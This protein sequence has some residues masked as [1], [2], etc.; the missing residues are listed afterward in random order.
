MDQCDILNAVGGGLG[1]PHKH[2]C[3][4]PQGCPLSMMLIAF[5]LRPWVL[6]MIRLGGVP[7]IL[8]DDM[9]VYAQGTNLYFIF[10][11]RFKDIADFREF[12]RGILDQILEHG[13]SLSHHHG[14]GKM[15]GPWMERHLG[16]EQVEILK[17]L[18]KHFDPHNIMN[19]GGTL[20]LD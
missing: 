17:A 5:L 13:G 18:K 12:H 11:G 1:K 9:L 7:R 4:I 19:P 2:Q 15:I 20:G 14:V 10:I 3:G 16:T 6:L 8:A